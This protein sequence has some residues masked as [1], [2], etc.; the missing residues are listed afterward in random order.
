MIDLD[1]F[2][3]TRYTRLSY[4]ILPSSSFFLIC[5]FKLEFMRL[6]TDQH[7]DACEIHNTKAQSSKIQ[8]KMFIILKCIEQNSNNICFLHYCLKFLEH[9][10]MLNIISLLGSRE[11]SWLG[12][13]VG[14]GAPFHCHRNVTAPQDYRVSNFD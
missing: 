3:D 1:H 5:I 6:E 10:A 12:T 14:W 13:Y 4:T 11:E 7:D 9:Y 2:W 8:K